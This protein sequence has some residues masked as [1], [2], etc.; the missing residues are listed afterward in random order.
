MEIL[1]MLSLNISET[2][3][4]FSKLRNQLKTWQKVSTS[5]LIILK[6]FKKMS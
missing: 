5:Y 1:F 2:H 4:A 6:C 3:R